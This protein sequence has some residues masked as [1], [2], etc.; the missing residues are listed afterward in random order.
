[1]PERYRREW[2]NMWHTVSVAETQLSRCQNKQFVSGAKCINARNSGYSNSSG[3]SP[4]QLLLAARHTRTQTQHV[5]NLCFHRNL[6]YVIAVVFQLWAKGDLN[7]MYTGQKCLCYDQHSMDQ[8]YS[9]RASVHTGFCI[10]HP[11]AVPWP[12]LRDIITKWGLRDNNHNF[13][14]AGKR[15]YA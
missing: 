11:T 15:A 13:L 2:C 10:L 12:T 8:L 7:I 1:M 3:N 9:A 4:A 14:C 6:T 5:I